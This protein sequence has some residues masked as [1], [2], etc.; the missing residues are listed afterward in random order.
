SFNLWQPFAGI[1]QP[2]KKNAVV[3]VNLEG[4][5]ADG[6]YP[7][8]I[9]NGNYSTKTKRSNSGIKSIQGEAN[10][11]KQ[12]NDSSTL[13][14]KAAEYSSA[15]GLPGAIIFF[16][17]RSVQRL[18][19]TDFFAQSRYQ[20]KFNPA[21]ALLV[22]AKY[23]NT[24]TRYT[25][26]DFL[27]NQGGLDERYAQQEVYGSIA[28]SYHLDKNLILTGASD[29]AF[30]TLAANVKNFAAPRRIS[31]WENV[32]VNYTRSRWKLNASLLYTGINDK[33]ATGTATDNKNKLTPAVALSIQ[34]AAESPLMLRFFYKAVFRMPTFNDLYYNFIGNSLLKPEYSKQYNAGIT[35]SK[36]FSS[37]VKRFSM[38]ADAYYNEVKDKIIAVPNQN[39]F[40]WTMLNLGKVSIKGVD[41]NV[42]TNGKLSSSTGW[43]VRLAYTW[44]Q[45][46]DI[47]DQ[48]SSSYK[49][50]IP[51]TPDHS[52]SGL[53]SFNYKKWDAG[54]SAL[55]SGTRYIL[56]NNSSYNELDGWLTQDIFVSRLVQLKQYKMH[57]KGEL[58]NIFD[59]RYDVIKYFPMPGRS[60][61]ISLLFNN[62]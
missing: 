59:E 54:Y 18:R 41:V 48:S 12:F 57:I 22:S 31:L 33:T 50:R 7:I 28:V 53:L 36:Q 55:F 40:V 6:N 37:A 43:F 51:Y 62:L 16:N 34:P 13:Q 19:N 27:N 3:S 15:R 32:G 29:I 11:L 23:S 2:L 56:G 17:D 38:G 20:K 49:D 9:D 14:V 61:K 39:L 8:Y 25:D 52:G 1:Y 26:P 46:L 47:T 60:F 4:L 45:A 21:T 42:E 24:Y 58:N 44:Q 30:N 10:L 5:Y 35:Y